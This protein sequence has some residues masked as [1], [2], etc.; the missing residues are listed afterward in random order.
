M[1]SPVIDL[2]LSATAV[3]LLKR[4]DKLSFLA[5]LPVAWAILTL[6]VR[7]YETTHLKEVSWL[8]IFVRPDYSIYGPLLAI[9]FY[10]SFELAP[11]FLK[12]N[13]GTKNLVGTTYEQ[14][15]A[16]NGP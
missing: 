9:G 5:I 2:L 14:T 6:V 12:S 10:Y 13:E 3:Y 7:N 8:P 16:N 11:I 1:Y 15:T 4:K